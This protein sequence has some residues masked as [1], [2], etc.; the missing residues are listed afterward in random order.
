MSILH[1]HMMAD[2]LLFLFVILVLLHEAVIQDNLL[3]NHASLAH[4]SAPM[5]ELVIPFFLLL[6]LHD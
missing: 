2:L 4:D 6:Y 1:K 5:L 3:C